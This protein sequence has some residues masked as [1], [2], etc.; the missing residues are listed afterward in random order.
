MT[1]NK[2]DEI[3]DTLAAHTD[4][5]RRDFLSSTAAVGGAMVVGFWLPPTHARAQAPPPVP[6][7]HVPAHLLNRHALVRNSGKVS[8]YIYI[9]ETRP[10]GIPIFSIWNS[11]RE[12]AAITCNSG[13][14]S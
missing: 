4:M 9:V 6:G 2:T 10:T 12:P 5:N 3:K 14:N 1:T 13:I 8:G 11:S 7:Q